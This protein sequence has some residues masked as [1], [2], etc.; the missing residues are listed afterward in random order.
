MFVYLAHP[1]DQAGHSSWLGGFLGDLNKLLVQ[2]GVGAFRP[3]HAYLANTA[4]ARHCEAI[5]QINNVAI[6]SADAMV[7]VLPKDVATLGTPA[8]IS[9]ALSGR[10][11]VAIFT[12]IGHSVQLAAWRS[13]GAAIYDMDAIDF[14]MPSPEELRFALDTTNIEITQVIPTSDFKLIGPPPLMITGQA[15][16]AMQGKYKG[17]AGI[18]LALTQPVS[19]A[20]GE[21]LLVPTGVFAAIPDG[22]FGW[23]TGRSSTWA[24]YRVDVRQAVIDHGYRGELMLGL[25]NRGDLT[26]DFEAGQRLGQL[27]I[28]PAFGGG[29]VAVDEL[30]ESERGTNGYGSSGR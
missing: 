26:A 25:E 16:N 19:V 12:D 20:P 5:D 15:A 17:D 18:D 11:P 30:P 10:K 14:E 13:K 2:A 6:W 21:Y 28:L 7:A 8:E 4:D 3:G 27:V 23:I 9:L 22:Y 29:I 24:N 1:I